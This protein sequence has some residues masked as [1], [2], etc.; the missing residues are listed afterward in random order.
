MARNKQIDANGNER[1]ALVTVVSRRERKA[2]GLV[3][4]VLIRL[5][6]ET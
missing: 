1:G 4:T 6:V 5:V 2:N 3:P